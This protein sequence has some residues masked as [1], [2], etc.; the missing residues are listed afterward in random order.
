MSVIDFCLRKNAVRFASNV[1]LAAMYDSIAFCGFCA[2]GA[3]AAK[4]ANAKIL[5]G[6]RRKALVSDRVDWPDFAPD[7]VMRLCDSIG[8]RRNPTET[9]QF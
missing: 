7:S 4:G 5:A 8:D 9:L 6:H 1:V 2:K 3:K